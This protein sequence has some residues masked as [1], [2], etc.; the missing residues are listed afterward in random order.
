M[1]AICTKADLSLGPRAVPRSDGESF[2]AGQLAE[3]LGAGA[4]ELQ[5][6]DSR[7]GALNAASS[8]Q[9]HI[10]QLIRDNSQVRTIELVVV[11]HFSSERRAT[12]VPLS[13][14]NTY[15]RPIDRL[16]NQE[17]LLAGQDNLPNPC[18]ASV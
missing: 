10:L 14:I 8:L 16:E 13:L 5:V 3:F 11:H 1:H 9:P 6:I 4:R 2:T 18:T 12:N 17:R 15:Y 7:V